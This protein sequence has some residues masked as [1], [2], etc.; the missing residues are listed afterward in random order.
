[1]TEIV[2][3]SDQRRKLE[4][5]PMSNNIV[6]SRIN[7]ISE[8]ILRQ[9]M[10]ELATSPFPFSLQLD[11]STDISY[12]SLLVCYVRYVNGKEIK[13]DFLFASLFW[14]L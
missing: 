3:G 2:C 9:V 8:N 11:E 1:M 12:C 13:E 10:E 6:K 5:I 7:D 14:K 4:G